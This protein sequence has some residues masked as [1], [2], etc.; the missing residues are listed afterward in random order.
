MTATTGV[1]AVEG[2][3]APRKRRRRRGGRRIE[4]AETDNGAPNAS[5][6]ENIAAKPTAPKP[7]AKPAHKP[8]AA[9]AAPAGEAKPSLLGRISRK[10]KSLVARPPRSQH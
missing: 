1:P 9:A 4:G 5:Q 6:G 7:A 2:E 10:L 8:A 3:R